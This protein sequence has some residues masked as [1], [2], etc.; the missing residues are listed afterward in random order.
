MSAVAHKLVFAQDAA[1]SKFHLFAAACV[2]TV[3]HESCD[4]Q[5]LFCCLTR[6]QQNQADRKEVRVLGQT[7]R[8]HA[9]VGFTE[10][11]YVSSYH[12]IECAAPCSGN[13]GGACEETKNIGEPVSSLHKN[14]FEHCP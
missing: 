4:F 6:E 2:S 9:E 7:G 14:K 10:Y 1:N 12:F 5:L 3:W 13:W 11:L 8:I